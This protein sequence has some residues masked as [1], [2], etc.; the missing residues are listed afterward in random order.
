MRQTPS[1]S[2]LFLTLSLFVSLSVALPL[3]PPRALSLCTRAK[4]SSPGRPAQVI[5][6][7]YQREPKYKNIDLPTMREILA[8]LNNGRPPMLRDV[9]WIM[10]LGDK[11]GTGTGV[12]MC[13]QTSMIQLHSANMPA[14]ILGLP[15]SRPHCRSLLIKFR[16]HIREQGGI[17]A[18]I[19]AIDHDGNGYLDDGEVHTLLQRATGAQPEVITA[20]DIARARELG[21]PDG[22]AP[23]NEFH[24]ENIA[25]AV[26]MVLR[27]AGERGHVRMDAC[28]PAE[29]AKF[30]NSACVTVY[31]IVP[32]DGAP[33]HSGSRSESLPNR[34][35]CST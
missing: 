16:N 14:S 34:S 19:K 25:K 3:P 27:M 15:V 12:R 4:S 32:S 5:F 35:C 6:D 29:T 33:K 7:Q 22:S 9:I 11:E 13:L 26:A 2:C 24:I 17:V 20:E 10:R 18:L 28:M 21:I 31:Q 8:A 30:S 23:G 1:V